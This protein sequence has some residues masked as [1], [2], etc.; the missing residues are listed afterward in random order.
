MGQVTA[1]YEPEIL[2]D[3]ED[4]DEVSDEEA[5]DNV[6]DRVESVFSTLHP[7]EKHVLVSAS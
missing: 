1:V 4:E 3:D 5:N 6:R 2:V 7:M